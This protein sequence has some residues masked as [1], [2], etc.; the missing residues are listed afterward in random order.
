MRFS[1]AFFLATAG[2]F[3]GCTDIDIAAAAEPTDTSPTEGEK[4]GSAPDAAVRPECEG[5]DDIDD[6]ITPPEEESEKDVLNPKLLL[7]MIA[8]GKEQIMQELE[9]SGSAAAGVL[10][11]FR[12]NAQ[13]YAES[14]LANTLGAIFGKSGGAPEE[15]SKLPEPKKAQLAADESRL[16][17]GKATQEKKESISSKMA[18]AGV[19]AQEHM[20]K[21]YHILQDQVTAFMDMGASRDAEACG[22][23]VMSMKRE[24]S[25]KVDADALLRCVKALAA[26]TF[27]AGMFV[28]VARGEHVKAAKNFASF[29]LMQLLERHARKSRLH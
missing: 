18:H 19:Q 4:V 16:T 21:V 13:D 28:N 26:F 15:D 29:G 5:C 2:I 25:L 23:V 17:A 20:E 24:T 14:A 22:E 6:S 11:K 10:K 12:Q 7:D 27:A 1:V 8:E 3:A 9:E